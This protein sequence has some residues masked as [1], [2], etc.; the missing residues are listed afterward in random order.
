MV[1]VTKNNDGNQR[2]IDNCNFNYNNSNN[3]NNDNRIM[4]V[5]VIALTYQGN[6]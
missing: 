4:Y 2:N 6:T 3:D 5:F 1:I